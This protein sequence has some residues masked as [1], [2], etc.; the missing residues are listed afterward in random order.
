M[1]RELGSRR[2]E[3]V[4]LNILGALSLATSAN[5]EAYRRHSQALTIA[6]EIG[7]RGEEAWA[8]AGMGQSLLSSNPAEAAVHLREALEIYQRIGSRDAQRT[9]DTLTEHGL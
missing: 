2:G 9:Q 6:R 1:H 7:A 4:L 8:L 5:E 3:A